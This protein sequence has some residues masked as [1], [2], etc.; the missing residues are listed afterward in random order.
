MCP[1]ANPGM[2]ESSAAGY[3]LRRHY[4]R[5]LLFEECRETGQSPEDLIN[6]AEKQKKK[7]KEKDPQPSPISTPVGS[8]TPVS[9][10]AAIRTP[11]QSA[12]TQLPSVG[13][14]QSIL[15]PTSISANVNFS[16][17]QGNCFK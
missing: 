2:Q 8:Q 13:G 15:Q 10:N 11:L 1:E 7:K 9:S 12:Q 17:P 4:Q 14:L 5:F 16:L 3:Q 6:F